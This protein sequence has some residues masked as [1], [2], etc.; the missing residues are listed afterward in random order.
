M[1]YLLDAVD[2][3][4]LANQQD[5]VRNER[6]QSIENQP[7]GIVQDTV[8]HELFPK[9]HPYYANVMGTHADIQAAKLDDVKSFF[10]QYY[11]PNNASLAIVGDFDKTTVKG[12]VEKYF[13]TLKRGPDVPPVTVTTPPITSERRAVVKDRVQL[14]RV[15]MAWLTPPFF[16]PGDADA[17]AT[18][19]VLGGGD[20]S[21]LYKT[22]VYDRQIAQNVSATQESLSLGSVFEIVATVRPGHTPAEV[23]Q[24]ITDAIENLRQHAPDAREVERAKNTFETQVLSGL[25]VL[26][27]FGG[28]ADTLNLFN[29]YVHDPGYLPTY[30]KEHRD[31]TPASV[32]AFAQKYLAPN[33]RV[34]VWAEPGQPDLGPNVPTPPAPK[35]AAGTGAESVNAEEA[36]RD[37][38]PAAGPEPTVSLPT[39]TSFTLDN[40]L[41]VIELPRPGMPV[42][43]ARLV[44]KTGGD[45]NP[46]DRSGLASFTASMLDQGTT[47]RNALTIADDA[48][49]IGASLGASSTKD[50]ISVGIGS[51]VRNFGGALDLLADVTLHP[52]FPQAEVDRQRTSRGAQLT[53]ATQDPGTVASVAA[54]N[55]LYGA[56]HPYGYIELG[57]RAALDATTRDDLVSFWQ[58]NFVPSNAALIVAG[59]MS[60]A[61][62]RP[63]VEKAFGAWPKAAAPAV[64]VATPEP[65]TPKIVIADLPGAPQT[66]LLVAGLGPARSTPDYAAINVMNDVLG[67]LF[68]SRINLN[69]REAHGY[70]YG[71][72]SQFVFRKGEGPFV[73]QAAVRTDA[74]APAVS[75]IFKEIRRMAASPMSADELTMA[76]DAIIRGLPSDFETSNSVV[77]ALGDLFVYNLGLDYYAKYPG[78]VSSVTADAALA[79]A[80]AY[81]KP[82]Q[83]IVVAAGDRAKI[84]APL[85]KLGIGP[86]QVQ[87]APAQ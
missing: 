19:S 4:K 69:L 78:M 87:P 75:E 58:H 40:G 63:L 83:M 15:Y 13:G 60:E 56:K 84:E 65:P 79:A 14:S 52:N 64:T 86:V 59:Q 5:V 35:V 68:S 72:G 12:L 34:V 53:A 7:Y 61:E 1:G 73:V 10:K 77:S 46:A 49:Q 25:E 44:L 71:A 62:L 42:A 55:A 54:M 30:L 11:R 6:R 2:Q 51:L 24:G 8:F 3:I 67:G 27:G 16:K 76:K 81:L 23:E 74:T 21:R 50:S 20:S 31:V 45:A 66:F 9:G 43:A 28:V 29:H 70:T 37:H 17:D 82:G 39:P 36:W 85:R 22:L 57:T 32:Q 18:A 47:T 41:T 33:A 80:K 26:G 48:A 38:P